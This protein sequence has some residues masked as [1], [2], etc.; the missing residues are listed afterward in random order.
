M[1]GR[2]TVRSFWVGVGGALGGLGGLGGLGAFGALGAVASF[3]VMVDANNFWIL[4]CRNC[5]D[6]SM[7]V[8]EDRLWLV[9]VT[10][11]GLMVLDI[12]GGK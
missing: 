10:S 11:N 12:V 9:P 7:I 5:T 8:L 1:G 4:D 3:A 2:W 6:S